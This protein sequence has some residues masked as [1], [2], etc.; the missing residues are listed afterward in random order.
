M[1]RVM[2]IGN[3]GSGKSTL[4]GKL[5]ALTG[6]PVVYGDR[7][8]WKENWVLRPTGERDAMF[9]EAAAQP[10]W[11]ID[12]N[13]SNTMEYRFARADTLIFL[14]VPRYLCVSRAFMRSIR[15]YGRNRPDMPAGCNER[16]DWEFLKWIW[17]YNNRGQIESPE[18]RKFT[19]MRKKYHRPAH[20]F[21]GGRFSP[22]CFETDQMTN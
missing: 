5:G 9:L 1:K 7:I 22:G 12:G 4:A 8:Q 20:H 2:I 18:I 10:A 3:A 6:L 14:D 21:S 15:Y 13:N 19:F 11:I 16:L 17:S